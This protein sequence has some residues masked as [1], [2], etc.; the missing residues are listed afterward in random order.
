MPAP[1][2][3]ASENKLARRVIRT[4]LNFPTPGY[5]ALDSGR[6][7][8]LAFPGATDHQVPFYRTQE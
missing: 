1:T 3:T 7:I 5:T 4:D 2:K 6:E 8:G